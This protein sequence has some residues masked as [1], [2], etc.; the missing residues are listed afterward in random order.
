MEEFKHLRVLFTWWWS[1]R[2]TGRL[3]LMS[4]Y[5]SI[6]FTFHP[7]LWSWVTIIIRPG[8]QG[9]VIS[10]GLRLKPLLHTNRRQF[11]W[12]GHLIRMPPGCVSVSGCGTGHAEED[13]LVFGFNMTQTQSFFIYTN[14]TKTMF[15]W[16]YWKWTD[17][18]VKGSFKIIV[19]ITLGIKVLLKKSKVFCFA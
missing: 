19:W 15:T 5:R 9:L 14:T 8:I 6:V 18:R 2:P 10:A 3:V 11:S 4:I 17:T 1:G 13:W 16:N 7:H 12:F